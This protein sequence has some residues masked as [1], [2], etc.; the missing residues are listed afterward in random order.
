M[1]NGPVTK[2]DLKAATQDIKEYVDERTHDAETRL[3]RAFVDY[4]ARSDVGYANWKGRLTRS[5]LRQPS[6]LANW[7]AV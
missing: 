4:S 1:D 5:T 6:A 3:L 2:A 7:S